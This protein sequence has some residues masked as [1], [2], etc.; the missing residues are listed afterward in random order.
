MNLE[1]SSAR[2]SE[3][4]PSCPREN[5]LLSKIASSV[6][7]APQESWLFLSWAP[8]RQRV[9]LKTKQTAV[10]L[11]CRPTVCTVVWIPFNSAPWVLSTYCCSSVSFAVKVNL[12]TPRH[13]PL[14]KPRA[15]E[16][17]PQPLQPSCSQLTAS[18]HTSAT[19]PETSVL[20]WGTCTCSSRCIIGPP[21]RRLAQKSTKH[22]QRVIVAS[23]SRSHAIRVL[24]TSQSSSRL[25]S[26]ICAGSFLMTHAESSCAPAGPRV[27]NTIESTALPHALARY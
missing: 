21:A 2:G 20:Y 10:F 27:Q 4:S 15:Y 9:F 13:Q 11:S 12:C 25:H 14:P 16:Y 8:W 23:V 26:F 1:T 5:T 24:E 17:F 7:L 19:T 6:F 22:G 3:V 18:M